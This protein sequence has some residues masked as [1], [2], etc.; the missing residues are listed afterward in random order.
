MKGCPQSRA[1]STCS[2]ILGIIGPC[3]HPLVS[4][5]QLLI[6]TEDGNKRRPW[7]FTKILSI[8]ALHGTRVTRVA[9]LIICN[10]ELSEQT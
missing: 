5:V 10:I 9:A 1:E 3:V 6:I 4:G 7:L 2:V 8:A